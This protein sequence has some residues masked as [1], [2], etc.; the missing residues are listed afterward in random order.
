M[1]QTA[2]DREVRTLINQLRA[3][4]PPPTLLHEGARI[5]FPLAVEASSPGLCLVCATPLVG[6]QESLCSGHWDWVQFEPLELVAHELFPVP[7]I[8]EFLEIFLCE[9]SV[10]SHPT[11]LEEARSGRSRCEVCDTITANVET[12]RT[13][14]SSA[15]KEHIVC[16]AHRTFRWEDEEVG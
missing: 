9:T 1:F 13:R 14:S 4:S 16:P 11:N 7:S 5:Y 6:R 8:I 15:I 10:W 2:R 3:G 12:L